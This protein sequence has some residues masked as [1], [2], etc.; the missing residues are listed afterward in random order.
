M[1]FS[2]TS[3]PQL[4]KQ[5]SEILGMPL[6]G[7]DISRFSNAEIYVRFKQSVRGGDVFV[8]QTLSNAVNDGLME[9]LIMIDALK[10]ASA[11]AITAV[12][13]HYGYS[14]QD[15][16]SKAR[17]PIAA[18]LIADLLSVAGINR[19]VT[20]D[21]HADSIQG[22]Y[23]MPVDHMTA[24]FLIANYFKNKK[25]KDI[26]VV[27]PDVGRVKTAKKFADLLGAGL[28]ILHKSRPAANVAEV[29]NGVGRVR[30][31]TALIIDDMIDTAGTITE[32]AKAVKDNG[33]LEIYA[34]ATHPIL[35]GPAIKRLDES[36]FEEVVITDTIPIAKDKVLDK[37]K[38]ISIAP[39]LAKVIENIHNDESVSTL[40]EGV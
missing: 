13:P 11:D 29:L 38:V 22:F 30:G 15:K 16:K 7:V 20:V 33:A 12:I 19:L 18:K 17:E 32:A 23:N 31:K 3:H 14:R 9:L 39:L 5:I 1:V 4:S 28:A 25:L 40:F 24:M 34:A 2:G 26:V 36:P 21:L 27:S 10:R 6:G 35:S 37:F 8:I